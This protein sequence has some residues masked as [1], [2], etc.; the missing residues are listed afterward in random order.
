MAPNNAS[1]KFASG[2]YS[3]FVRPSVYCSNRLEHFVCLHTCL[4]LSLACLAQA[5]SCPYADGELTGRPP[6][7]V[8]TF[9]VDVVEPYRQSKHGDE[10][11]VQGTVHLSGMS[12]VS[13]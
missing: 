4:M 13:T 1:L 9:H 8:M 6:S 11:V 10:A 2:S 3:L 12:L 5:V 7:Y